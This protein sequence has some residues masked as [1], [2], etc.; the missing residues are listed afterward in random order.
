MRSRVAPDAQA[1]TVDGS[2]VNLGERADRPS[3]VVRIEH[4]DNGVCV[5][6]IAVCVCVDNESRQTEQTN[7]RRGPVAW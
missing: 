2:G 7:G 5:S 4:I 1:P 6:S 3:A